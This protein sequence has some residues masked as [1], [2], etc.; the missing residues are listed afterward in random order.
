ME[1]KRAG[2]GETDCRSR[3]QADIGRVGKDANG[4]PAKPRRN[5]KV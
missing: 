3:D 4:R 2:D 1:A 5:V